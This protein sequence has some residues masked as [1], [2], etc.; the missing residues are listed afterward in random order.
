MGDV[1]KV[2]GKIE[3]VNKQTTALIVCIHVSLLLIY[4][5]ALQGY[6]AEA[7]CKCIKRVSFP[8]LLRKN[9][10]EEG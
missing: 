7:T 2:K 5:S 8:L 9:D 6:Q 3:K 10:I 1:R 4:F